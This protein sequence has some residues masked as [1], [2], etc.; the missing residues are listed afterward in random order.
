M[1]A[2]KIKNR[3]IFIYAHIIILRLKNIKKPME[4]E[5]ILVVTTVCKLSAM[6]CGMNIGKSD[7]S[8]FIIGLFKHGFTIKSVNPF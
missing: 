6:F 5:R 8:T 3:S 1:V 4:T 7:V 2:E